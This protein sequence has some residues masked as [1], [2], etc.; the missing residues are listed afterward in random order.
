M[1]ALQHKTLPKDNLEV[2]VGLSLDFRSSWNIEIDGV[3]LVLP[4]E[5]SCRI[6]AIIQLQP[7]QLMK[8][9]LVF[10]STYAKNFSVTSY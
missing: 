1:D 10:A 7:I 8:D 6:V 3:H 5:M 9:I 4:N 2:L